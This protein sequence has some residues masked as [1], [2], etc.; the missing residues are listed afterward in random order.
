M[1][2]YVALL[3]GINV[4]GKNM[5]RMPALKE[6]F[7]AGGFEDVATYIQS[8]NVLFR[9]SGGASALAD[10]IEKMLSKTFTHYQATVVVRSR[11]QMRTTIEKAPKGFGTKPKTYLSDAIFLKEPLTAAAALKQV[12]TK[13]GVDEIHAGRGVLYMQRLA[14]KAS[15]SR[16]SRVAALPIYKKMTIRS[17]NTTTRLARM[18]E[19]LG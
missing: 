11:T 2:F 18:M 15:S 1:G 19:E 12:P 13:E 14:S 5:I 17:W 9:A 6:C 4:G 8:G 10:R 16:L 3:R 7:E